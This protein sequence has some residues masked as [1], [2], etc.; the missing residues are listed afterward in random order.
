MSSAYLQF[1]NESDKEDHSSSEDH[2]SIVANNDKHKFHIGS[3]CYGER[4]AFSV[5]T[6]IQFDEC[7]I[8]NLS[9]K[10]R[11]NVKLSS[12]QLI[13]DS[14]HLRKAQNMHQ[15]HKKNLQSTRM[16]IKSHRSI[17]SV[18]KTAKQV[19]LTGKQQRDETLSL[20]IYVIKI[21]DIILMY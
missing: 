13:T 4:K 6:N 9:N 12:L 18:D 15:K 17:N 7:V 11:K 21:Q 2:E 16:K 5:I 10:Q 19:E 20:Y 3:Y 14:K 8:L 1:E